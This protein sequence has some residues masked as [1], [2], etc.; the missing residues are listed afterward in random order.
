MNSWYKRSAKWPDEV[1][2]EEL[3][4]Y[5]GNISHIS[6]TRRYK[7]DIKYIRYDL[8]MNDGIMNMRI[9]N[10]TDQPTLL[11]CMSLF[12]QHWHEAK[13]F[14]RIPRWTPYGK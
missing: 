14:S 13:D 1:T 6:V 8:D 4:F 5:N 10:I 7:H 3:M 11:F 9:E 2:F 12:I